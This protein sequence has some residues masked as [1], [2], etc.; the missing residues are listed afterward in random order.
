[1]SK[2]RATTLLA[3]FVL[4]TLPC[5]AVQQAFLWTSPNASRRFPCH[6]HRTV[7]RWFGHRINVI[8]APVSDRPCLIAANH[9]SWLDIPI[10]SALTPLSF[11][12]KKEVAKWPGFGALAKLQRSVFIDRERRHS[13]R[14]SRDEI[15]ERFAAGETIVLFAEGTSGDGV[16]VLPF[17]SAYFGAAEHPGVVIQPVTLAYRGHWGLPM[18]RRSRPFYA[19][20]GD[21]EMQPH[22]WGAM[23]AGPIEVDIICHPPTSIEQAGGRK[24]AAKYAETMVRQGLSWALSRRSECPSSQAA[25]NP[26]GTPA[27]LGLQ[28][29]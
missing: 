21:M 2:A 22:L 19:W 24:A 28:T 27:T 6:Y 3:G 17:K 11:I 10:L 25:A 1:M 13:T 14:S 5:M 29:E 12:A 23:V 8:G 16:T 26:L 4:G 15:K 7:L 9:V 18:N 20:Y